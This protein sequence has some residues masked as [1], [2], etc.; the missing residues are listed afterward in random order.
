MEANTEI[1]PFKQ[2]VKNW[3]ASYLSQVNGARGNEYLVKDFWE[4]IEENI[5][6]YIE[7]VG[8]ARWAFQQVKDLERLIKEI[9]S[10]GLSIEMITTEPR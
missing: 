1:E 4:E 5:L 10:N 6:P 2:M 3:K 8:F 9:E 7:S